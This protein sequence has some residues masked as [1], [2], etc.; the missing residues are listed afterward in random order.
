[1]VFCLC[2]KHNPSNDRH[3]T[4]PSSPHSFYYTF[5]YVHSQQECVFLYL[6]LARK[7]CRWLASRTANRLLAFVSILRVF[8]WPQCSRYFN[9]RKSSGNISQVKRKSMN[10]KTLITRNCEL[11]LV[12]PFSLLTYNWRWMGE[13]KFNLFIMARTMH[14]SLRFIRN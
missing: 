5:Y 3:L 14:T 9:W 10:L 2:H 12:L 1:M 11:L 8:P 7:M 4:T 6:C 13:S